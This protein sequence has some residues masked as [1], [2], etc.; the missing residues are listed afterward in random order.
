MAQAIEPLPVWWPDDPAYWAAPSQPRI[1]TTLTELS[2]H[3]EHLHSA[4]G[5]CAGLVATLFVEQFVPTAAS[6]G[7]SFAAS[8]GDTVTAGELIGYFTTVIGP[9]NEITHIW[10]FADHAD[11]SRRRA[12]LMADPAWRG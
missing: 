2:L 5:W 6:D 8:A 10:A 7:F 3:A 12:E 9:L 1:A 11:R 4:L